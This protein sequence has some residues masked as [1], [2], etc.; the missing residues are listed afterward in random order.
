MNK[1]SLPIGNECLKMENS[2]VERVHLRQLS[3]SR[4]QIDMCFSIFDNL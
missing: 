2:Q 3:W 4:H 1:N